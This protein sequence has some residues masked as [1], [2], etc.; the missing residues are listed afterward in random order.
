M[1]KD[2]ADIKYVDHFV[3]NILLRSSLVMV[4]VGIHVLPIQRCI[5][6]Y[7]HQNKSIWCFALHTECIILCVR[8]SASAVWIHA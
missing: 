3:Y 5:P 2:I 1:S 7:C 8:E 4:M 6:F